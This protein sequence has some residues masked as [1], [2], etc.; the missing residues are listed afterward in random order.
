MWP[1][2]SPRTNTRLTEHTPKWTHHTSGASF[3]YSSSTLCLEFRLISASL[4]TLHI[5]WIFI[6]LLSRTG[7][8]PWVL[9]HCSPLVRPSEPCSS[10]VNRL[11]TLTSLGASA[12]TNSSESFTIS[13][14]CFMAYQTSD[15][16][17]LSLCFTCFNASQNSAIKFAKLLSTA[18]E[19]L[20]IHSS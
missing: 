17:F 7:C 8:L 2:N 19:V 11:S 18:A 3:S 13:R 1:P 6:S 10:A 20:D 4:S 9:L 5:K 12:A 16:G 15:F 14:Y